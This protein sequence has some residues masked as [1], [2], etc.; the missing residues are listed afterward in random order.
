MK[1]VG[2]DLAWLERNPS[3]IAVIEADGTLVRATAD[4]WTNEEI[5]NYSR[6]ADL[7][8][9]IV[10]ID[11]PLIVKNFDEQRPVERQLTQ[12]FGNYD[13]GPHSASLKNPAFQQAGRIQR[14][15]RLL[16]SLGFQQQ[17]TPR[18][19]QPQRVFR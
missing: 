18:K 13:A 5:V 10:T 15:I 4:R 7:E 16:E 3:G 9:V 19:Q 12:L 6:L 1:F 8:D 14:L 17:P 11:A 2:I